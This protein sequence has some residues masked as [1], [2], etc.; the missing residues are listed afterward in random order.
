MRTIALTIILAILAGGCTPTKGYSDKSVT[1]MRPGYGVMV[2]TFQYVPGKSAFSQSQIVKDAEYTVDRLA[3]L[4]YDAFIVYTGGNTTRVG[5]HEPTHAAAE[6]L[7]RQ[8]EAKG[9]IALGD[10][11]T[12]VVRDA[13]IVNIAELKLRALSTIP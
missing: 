4:R 2:A 13:E 3:A 7:K 6:G 1:A 10:G 9:A 8:L 12:I 5:I 11:R